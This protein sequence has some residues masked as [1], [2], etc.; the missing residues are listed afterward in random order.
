M[1]IDTMNPQQLK[2]EFMSISKR[3]G[4]LINSRD[5]VKKV[6][7]QI[8][9]K[10][11]K[12]SS[13]NATVAYVPSHEVLDTVGLV[14]QNDFPFLKKYFLSKYPKIRNPSSP[15]HII[16]SSLDKLEPIQ[17]EIVGLQTRIDPIAQ[18]LITTGEASPDQL[19]DIL[20][21]S[22]ID[23]ARSVTPPKNVFI[24]Q[25]VVSEDMLQ[26]VQSEMEWINKNLWLFLDQ[27]N[28]CDMVWN[29]QTLTKNQLVQYINNQQYFLLAEMIQQ[30]Y[31]ET[32]TT[33]TNSNCSQ[34]IRTLSILGNLKNRIEQKLKIKN[35][36]IPNINTVTLNS[37]G[38]IVEVNGSFNRASLTSPIVDLKTRILAK[39]VSIK[40]Q[41]NQSTI[42]EKQ[43]ILNA[44][45]LAQPDSERFYLY[46]HNACD[47]ALKILNVYSEDTQARTITNE[48]N[49]ILQEIQNE[50]IKEFDTYSKTDFARSGIKTRKPFQQNQPVQEENE[51]PEQKE[52]PNQKSEQRENPNQKSEQRENPKQKS[53]QRE[54]PN[55][56]SEQRENPKQRQQQQPQQHKQQ[57]RP[58]Q[59]KQ[60]EKEQEEKVNLTQQPVQGVREDNSNTPSNPLTDLKDKLIQHIK[61][62]KNLIGSESKDLPQL[63]I[64]DLQDSQY[65]KIYTALKGYIEK[66]KSKR[67][68]YFNDFVETLEY[69]N[70]QILILNQM[71]QNRP[72]EPS[73]TTAD[74]MLPPALEK[75]LRKI[76]EDIDSFDA[77]LKRIPQFV[78]QGKLTEEQAQQ[79]RDTIT[80]FIERGELC[81]KNP[82]LD[83]IQ[84][85]FNK[86]KAAFVELETTA[87]KTTQKIDVAMKQMNDLK[88][89]NEELK[90]S[91]STYANQKPTSISGA[92]QAYS[93]AANAKS[94]IKSNESDLEKMRLEIESDKKEL[95]KLAAY[96]D[97]FSGSGSP[98]N[99][100]PPNPNPPN[101]GSNPPNPILSNPNP[102]NPNPSIPNSK[103]NSGKDPSPGKP[104]T[105]SKKKEVIPNQLK[106]YIKSGV[107]GASYFLY[108]G[109]MTIKGLPSDENNILFDPLYPLNQSLINKIPESFRQKMFFNP[110]LFE[111]LANYHNVAKDEDTGDETEGGF[112]SSILN[113]ALNAV[114]PSKRVKTLEEARSL[115]YIDNNVKVTLDT[116][117]QQKSIIYVEGAPYTVIDVQWTQ[118]DWHVVTKA[119][120]VEFN[121]FYALTPGQFVKQNN[122]DLQE[123]QEQLTTLPK[124]LLVGPNFVGPASPSS[125]PPPPSP[126]PPSNPPLLTSP[127]SSNPPLLTSSSTSSP[128]LLTSSS[129]SNPLTLTSP[130]PF[131]NP[132]LAIESKDLSE[133][134]LEPLRE[135]CDKNDLSEST[136][137]SNLVKK[138]PPC[139]NH[140][141][142]T[143]LFRQYFE[144]G[145]NTGSR[146]EFYSM[147]NC[148][149]LYL[150]PDVSL[151]LRTLLAKTTTTDVQSKTKNAS[152]S[153]YEQT[154]Q[155]LQVCKIAG[156]GNCF[157]A[158]IQQAINHYNNDNP[159]N[160]IIL[161]GTEYGRS[162][163]FDIPI[164]RKIVF[165]HVASNRATLE[166]IYNQT[167]PNVEEL[168]N[169]VFQE[170]RL[171]NQLQLFQNQNVAIPSQSGINYT[172]TWDWT[173]GRLNVKNL[174]INTQ[175]YIN[176]VKRAGNANMGSILVTTLYNILVIVT[177]GIYK[178]NPAINSYIL[179][180]WQFQ[181]RNI[182]EFIQNDI[183]VFQRGEI[184]SIFILFQF[185]TEIE[186][187]GRSYESFFKDQYAI[188]IPFASVINQ[189]F[190]T[191][192]LKYYMESVNY[193]A[194]V[195]AFD[196]MIV[197]LLIN[198]IPIT[199][200]DGQLITV[201]DWQY[202]T[203][204]EL[205]KNTFNKYLFLYF[206]G[207][208]YE[209]FH[210]TYNYKVCLPAT[211]SSQPKVEK[212]TKDTY[213]FDYP[214]GGKIAGIDGVLNI[215]PRNMPPL[216][217][218]LL[219]L[220]T[221]YL[222][223]PPGE[224]IYREHFAFFPFIFQQLFQTFNEIVQMAVSTDPAEEERITQCI[225][226]L[227]TFYRTFQPRYLEIIT[228]NVGSGGITPQISDWIRS[229][230]PPNLYGKWYSKQRKAKNV[231]N[232]PSVSDRVLRSMSNTNTSGGAPNADTLNKADQLVSKYLDEL[233]S[234]GYLQSNEASRFLKTTRP[235]FSDYRNNNS[236]YSSSPYNS[237]P[238]NSS[239]YNSSP[240][241]N[242]LLGY[243]RFSP[244][245]Q[246]K[247]PDPVKIAYSITVEMTLYPGTKLNISDHINIQC[248]KSGN[249][250]NKS[251]HN[252][253]GR[254]YTIK[255]IWKFKQKIDKT[256]KKGD[257]KNKNKN[258]NPTFRNSKKS[259]RR[260]REFDY[261]YNAVP[262]PYSSF[263]TFSHL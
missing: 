118:G 111:S 169:S 34:I 211:S 199:H 112:F 190:N 45:D 151:M 216:Y 13:A 237:S 157:F 100:N 192:E 149:F 5:R 88:K 12:I 23:A 55:Q 78:E 59:Q 136:K 37:D 76:Q 8:L 254:P 262:P 82:S 95:E 77:S 236:L 103:P 238:Y 56:K 166:R 22:I 47:I 242:P 131:N 146:D 256:I 185:S 241:A 96:N 180:K 191:N 36:K 210:F 104:E 249:A 171:W 229:Q 28:K 161:A 209:P 74:K 80:T 73:N 193:W 261:P 225:D 113:S 92:T 248:I 205:G 121:K 260:N 119:S 19:R 178:T 217:I 197:K 165:Q 207:S 244:Y 1:N 182:N 186:D 70:S 29:K 40:K 174:K 41:I 195:L 93:F 106:V 204:D 54:N 50:Y 196:A 117:F 163:N 142:A 173:K 247:K 58:E 144:N 175:E 138:Q 233:V 109:D 24:T 98:S 4:E 86:K 240:Y 189:T 116:L 66:Y 31:P 188:L 72:F 258:K 251:V 155:G 30:E 141:Q 79:I 25:P 57:H 227:N 91:V 33:T 187:T 62:Y 101:P 167:I 246:F 49:G 234:E 212:R 97:L 263:Y 63:I 179:P 9:T 206:D 26:T 143:S 221:K 87:K 184:P 133:P 168:N 99:Q 135:S 132:L 14:E 140:P 69:V 162:I 61:T 215:N 172:L 129:S 60:P 46:L 71:Q 122:R 11:S 110:G 235:Y 124:K 259:T 52:N 32:L 120:P 194:D 198:P 219:I 139:E 226:F 183:A 2:Q 176:Y 64:Q 202:S 43:E 126:S 107:P 170:N 152:V 160:R 114:R 222:S 150:N 154:V 44:L 115:G 81:I 177:N 148:M 42:P 17:T 223:W 27:L 208:H 127:P 39:V 94:T 153:A 255:P 105:S 89:D 75:E 250:L 200:I 84:Q 10:Q 20:K 158:S 159:L 230:N 65:E 257:N 253:I 137:S 245:Q 239:P 123:G 21:K 38:K 181:G 218:F 102:S 214:I 130:P 232:Q 7:N 53:E 134:K 68:P 85:Y 18:K 16:L 51:K 220:G 201:Q 6:L 213:I 125:P 156:D 147:I 67:N 108:R 48:L 128:P 90:K 145:I 228:T 243:N 164:L 224:N 15:L 83:E 3:R 231:A 35:Y 252:L 203:T